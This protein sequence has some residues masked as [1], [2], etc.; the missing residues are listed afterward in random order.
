V[1]QCDPGPYGEP[2]LPSAPRIYKTKAKNAQEAHEAIRPTELSRLPDQVKKNLD[3][4][5]LRSTR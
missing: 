4:D 1:P 2:Y 3:A 5:Q